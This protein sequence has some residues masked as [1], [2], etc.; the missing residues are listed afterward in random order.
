MDPIATAVTALVHARR[1]GDATPAVTLPDAEAAYAVQD[2]VAASLGWFE[3]AAP[4]HWKSGAPSAEAPQTHAP[5][6]PEGV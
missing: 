1:S 2:G 6:P 4:W 5:L 3:N